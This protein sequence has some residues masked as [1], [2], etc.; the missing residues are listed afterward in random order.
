MILR[1]KETREGA[2]NIPRKP[3]SVTNAVDSHRSK[4]EH[5]RDDSV[6]HRTRDEPRLP[7]LWISHEANP[8]PSGMEKSKR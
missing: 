7:L 8:D 4:K 3:E 1:E 5:I 6:S 2:T